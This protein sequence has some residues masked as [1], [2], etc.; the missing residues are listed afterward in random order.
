MNVTFHALGSFATAAVLSLK[1]TENWRSISAL[2]K[3]LI[4][5]AGGIVVHGILDLLPHQ[6][7]IPS[8]VDV[9]LAPLLLLLFLFVSQKQNFLLILIC[10]AGCVFPDVIDLGP[11]IVDKYLG[12]ALPRLP[13]R[14]FPWHTTKYS[15]SIY[16]G[17]RVVESAV[18][19]ILFSLICLSLL[20]IC[21]KNIFRF[22]KNK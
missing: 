21:R 17:S 3:Y 22:W 16:D 10:F 11:V 20:Y 1:I 14:L 4:G 12:I 15:G 8:K 6:Y 5:F 18:Y 2:K 7:P 9:I 13:F 19:H